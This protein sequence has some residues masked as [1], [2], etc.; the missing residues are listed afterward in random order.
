M[1]LVWNT[2]HCLYRLMKQNELLFFLCGDRGLNSGPYIYY[3]SIPIALS[4][5]EHRV[6]YLNKGYKAL[7]DDHI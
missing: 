6:N 1:S 5:R 3:L 4:S 2:I 7:H